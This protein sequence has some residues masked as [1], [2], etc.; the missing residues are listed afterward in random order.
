MNWH[1]IRHGFGWARLLVALAAAALSLRAGTLEEDFRSPPAATR[2]FVYWYWVNNNISKEGIRKDLRAMADVGIGG[3]SIAQIEYKDTPYGRT[4]IFSDEWWDCLS[5]ALEEAGRL[6]MEV[7][8]FNSPGWSGIGGAWVKPEQAMRYLDVHEYQVRGPKKLAMPLP[9]YASKERL[10]QTSLSFQYEIDKATFKFQPVSVQAFPAPKGSAEVISAKKPAVVSQ[11][12]VQGIQALF[13]GDD[14]TTLAVAQL[15]VKIELSLNEPFTM[16][17]LELIPAAPS[18]GWCK[19][20]YL[21]EK[22]VWVNIVSRR[23]TRSENRIIASG[24]WPMA[25]VCAGFPAVTA[26]EFRLTLSED[27]SGKARPAP[28]GAGA[29]AA[30]ICLAEVRLGATE[31]VDSYPEK[32]LGNKAAYPK[33]SS[34]RA[35]AGETPGAVKPQAVRDLTAQVSAQGVLTWDVPEGDWIIQHAGMLQTGV[36]T[37]PVPTGPTRGFAADALSKEANEVCFEAYV[38]QI[39]KR[40]PPEKRKALRRVVIDSYEQG[41]ANW[42]DGLAAKFQAAYGYNPLPWTPVLRGHVVGSLDQSERFLWDL[43]RLVADLMPDNFAGAIHE[44]AAQNGLTLWHEPY[45]GHGFPGECLSLGKYTEMPA[46]EFWLR[47]TPG[48]EFPQCRAAASV[49]SVYGRPLVSV[50]AFT[51]AGPLYKAVPRELKVHGDWGLAQGLNH[52]TFHVYVH[53]PDDRAPGINTWYGTEFNRHNNWFADAKSYVDYV[54]RSCALLQ[55][56]RRQADVACYLGDEVPCD[57]P[58]LGYPF[59]RGYDLDFVNYDMLLNLAKVEQ[60]RLVMPSGA[61]YR[62]LVLP[63]AATMRPELLRKLESFVNAGLAL[64]GP[65][66]VKSPSLKNFPECDAQVRAMADRLWGNVDGKTVTANRA[67]QGQVFFGGELGDVLARL[68]VA[69]DVGMPEGFVYSHRHTDEA[70]IYFIANQK[71]EA[72]AADFSFRAAGRAPELWDALTGEHRPL[73]QHTLEKDRTVVPLQFGPAGACLVVFRQ[74]SS[75]ATAARENYPAYVPAK[76]IAGKWNVHFASR[77]APT[78][79]RTFEQLTD[80]ATA[81]DPEVKYFCGRAAYALDFDFDGPLPGRWFL[82]LGRVE[83]LAK[84]R[85][86][87]RDVTTL[88]CYPYRADISEY[89]LRGANKLEVE[90]VNQWWNRLIGDEQPGAARHTTVSARLFWKPT[91]PL[92]P[93]GL[94]GPVVL[95][96]ARQDAAR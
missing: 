33:E 5:V 26:K 83:S 24:W 49:A 34:A 67:G 11:P 65:R 77:V 1:K 35:A 9:D 12:A 40:I 42:T 21:D 66:P 36:P 25:P 28:K 47:K 55:K 62:L 4:T 73:P 75:V 85:L 53:Q 52:F 79:D 88:W 71:E 43:R 72:R 17:S 15:P 76:T 32:Q 78:F 87:G 80:W 2:P 93:A 59:P 23:I 82:N 30:K 19:L 74:P 89:L 38:G 69:P 70:E 50:E 7:N 31:R 37:H 61:A 10:V 94:I 56:G 39:L 20:D 48:G 6:G 18:S 64:Y 58:Q 63:K 68:A 44:K 27:E 46:G 92:A 22:G 96:T 14:S 29:G 90:V 91:D 13:D 81:S 86:N 8:L 60:G 3:V 95:E 45:G 57:Y 41:V 51:S 84:V 54:R 16:R